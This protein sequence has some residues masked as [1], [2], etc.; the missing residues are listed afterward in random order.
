MTITNAKL[1][2]S[3]AAFLFA[4]GVTFGL[5]LGM[6]GLIKMDE[7]MLQEV[8]QK[9][10]PNFTQA[11]EDTGVIVIGIQRPDR[12]DEAQDT[13]ELLPTIIEPDFD[14]DAVTIDNPYRPNSDSDVGTGNSEY[15]PVFMVP[16]VYPRGPLSRGLCGWVELEFTVTADGTTRDPSIMASSSR[17]FERAAINAALK[18]KYKPRHVGGKPVDVPNVPIR[19]VFEMEEGC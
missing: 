2:T 9:V 4:V 12:P 17:M 13:P 7:P 15:L 16:P 8:V 5:V 10:L 11:P 14:I 19:I 6:Y 3:T 1:K 18:Y